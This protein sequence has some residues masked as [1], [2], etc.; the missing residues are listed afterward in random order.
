MISSVSVPRNIN[1]SNNN[2][3]KQ[4]HL[5]RERGD[6]TLWPDVAVT[7][8]TFKSRICLLKDKHSY[9]E[10]YKT[11]HRSGT[12]RPAR[13]KQ[14]TDSSL[15]F[16]IRVLKHKNNAL[17]SRT[18]SALCWLCSWFQ[19]GEP[20]RSWYHEGGAVKFR[21]E[22]NSSGAALLRDQSVSSRF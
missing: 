9:P 11:R 7:E 4:Q 13:V 21:S 2:S 20:G 1:N 3:K 6:K 22:L 16:A 10:K 15:A 8:R 19:P 14:A 17:H 12:D 5:K 18:Y